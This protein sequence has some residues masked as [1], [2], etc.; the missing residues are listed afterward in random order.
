MLVVRLGFG[1]EFKVGFRVR[2]RVL[3]L[4]LRLGLGFVIGLGD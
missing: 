3:G 1:L 4:R 2:I